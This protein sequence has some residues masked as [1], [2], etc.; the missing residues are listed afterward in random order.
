MFGNHRSLPH[1]RGK[2]GSADH[3]R[4]PKVQALHNIMILRRF[5]VP[6]EA[7]PAEEDVPPIQALSRLNAREAAQSTV[8]WLPPVVTII[9]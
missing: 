2:G 8:L 9:V 3:L 6:G 4:T 1:Y 5:C 7:V